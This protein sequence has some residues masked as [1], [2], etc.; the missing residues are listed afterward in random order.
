MNRIANIEL[1]GPYQIQLAFANGQSSRLDLRPLIGEGMSA[2]LLDPDYFRQ[3]TIEPGGGLEWPN[4]F[5]IC[6]NLL[7][8]LSTAQTGSAAFDAAS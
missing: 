6:P 8:Q 5:D 2:A 1:L 4:G 3:V 7:W